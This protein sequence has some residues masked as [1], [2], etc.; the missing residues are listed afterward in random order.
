MEKI[1][2]ED[3]FIWDQEKEAKKFTLSKI[4]VKRSQF[5]AEIIWAKP[6]PIIPKMKVRQPMITANPVKGIKTILDKMM[7]AEN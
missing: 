7:M 2:G 4:K 1:A 3:I 6:K 5:T